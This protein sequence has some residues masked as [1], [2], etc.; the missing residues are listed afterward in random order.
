MNYFCLLFL[1]LSGLKRSI[2]IFQTLLIP[3][4]HN[5]FF[6]PESA[7]Q[8]VRASGGPSVGASELL[9]SCSLSGG[10][11]QGNSTEELNV[12]ILPNHSVP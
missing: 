1:P 11:E 9:S 4:H 2:I 12:R 8:A 7:A 5:N 6:D 10:I 3:A